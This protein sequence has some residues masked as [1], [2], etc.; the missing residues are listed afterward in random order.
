M[1]NKLFTVKTRYD[2]RKK[3]IIDFLYGG[4]ISNEQVIIPFINYDSFAFM[5]ALL[6]L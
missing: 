4:N 5:A 2:Q 6:P 3:I 1:A